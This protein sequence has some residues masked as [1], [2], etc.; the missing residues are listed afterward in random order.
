M[1]T[2]TITTDTKT[3]DTTTND[4]WHNYDQLKTSNYMVSEYYRAVQTCQG[5]ALANLVPSKVDQALDIACGHGET[6]KLLLNFAEQVVGVDSSDDLVTK[7]KMIPTPNLEFVCSTFEEYQPST[8][9]DL[10]S[11]TWFLNHVH[12]KQ[13]LEAT[14]EKIKSM[15]NPGGSVCFVT[16]GNSFTS[17]SVQKIALDLFQWRQAWFEEGDGFTRGVLSYF[18]NWI[19]TTIWQPVF[20][21]KMLD[22][23]FDVR[24]WDVKR[25]QIENHLLSEFNVE[26]PFEVIYGNLR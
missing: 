20:L 16:P 24:T 5:A 15:L 14:I 11:A 10:I 25:T 6:S 13:D 17:A 21:M 1:S 23:H 26:P 2:V 3:K 9:F 7:A 22:N 4:Q 19:P 12:S 18:G 8:K